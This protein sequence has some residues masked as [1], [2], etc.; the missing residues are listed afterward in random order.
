MGTL[1]TSNIFL[2]ISYAVVCIAIGIW[3]TFKQKDNDFLIAGR[4]LT[5]F[6]FVASVVAGYIGGNSLVAYTAFV[7]Q[8][9]LSAISLFVGTSIG[10]L[11]FIYYA[12][13]IRRIGKEKKFLTLSDWFYEKFDKRSGFVSSIMILLV[14]FGFLMN[15]FIAGSSIL[16][17]ISGWS[18]EFALFISGAVIVIYLSLGGFNSVI[19][20]DIFQY[21]V[22]LVLLIMVGFVMFGEKRSHVVDL[23]DSSHLQISKIAA[24]MIYGISYVFF[25]A[26]YWQKTYAAKDDIVIKKGLR[27]SAI[28]IVISGLA[29]SLIGLYAWA[30]IPGLEAKDAA[31][32]GLSALLPQSLTGLGLMLVFAAIMSSAD[33]MVFVLSTSVAK[34]YVARFKTQKTDEHQLK[35]ITRIFIVIFSILSVGGAFFFRDIISLIL[36]VTGI[37]FSLIPSV[38]ASFH[39]KIHNVA[40]FASLLSGFVYILILIITGNLMSEA[41]VASAIVSAL[42]LLVFQLFLRKKTKL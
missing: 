27:G 32:S 21:L 33:T 17:S 30:Y 35:K 8:Y 36:T 9:G 10:F 15:Q 38:I 40:A 28:L 26:E 34:D 42:V 2:L 11:L 22:L 23:F 13:R 25:S 16:S 29:L 41:A 14:Y 24:F 7:Y 6:G 39:W 1:S 37:G 19:R 12:L 20:T 4:K 5:T 18:Y 31:A 3:S